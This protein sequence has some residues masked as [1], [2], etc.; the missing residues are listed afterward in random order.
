[1]FEMQLPSRRAAGV[2]LVRLVRIL[3]H[4]FG[5]LR[6]FPAIQ[7]RWKR[8]YNIISVPS[9]EI[10]RAIGLSAVLAEH[11]RPPAGAIIFFFTI[12]AFGLS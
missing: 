5:E 7:L 11:V 10:I 9:V 3:E 12:M 8:T 1:M 4:D 6:R 2:F